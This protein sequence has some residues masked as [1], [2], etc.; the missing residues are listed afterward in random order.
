MVKLENYCIKQRQK[1][2]R[3][4]ED[5]MTYFKDEQKEYLSKNFSDLKLSGQEINSVVFEECSFKDCDFSKVAFIDCKFIECHFSKC[6]LSVVKLDH[7]RFTDVIFEDCKVIGVDWTK[8]TWP[9]IVLFSPVKFFKCIINDSAFFGLSLNEI[10]V[11]ECKAYDV[12]FREGNFS[13]ANFMFTDFTNSL[14]NE[15]NL[16]GADFTEAVNYRI[17]I[18]HNRISRAKFSRHEAVSLLES[19]EIELID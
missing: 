4:R 13:E 14:F 19:L 6:N 2:I 16:T 15:T 3:N 11:E 10:V 7:S 17:D 9:S 8:A 5:S 1:Y 18:N 12:D